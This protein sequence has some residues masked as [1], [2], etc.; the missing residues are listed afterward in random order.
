MSTLTA[1]MGLIKPDLVD[2]R[3][4]APFNLNSDAIDARL[5]VRPTVLTAATTLTMGG[6]YLAN[7]TFAVTL[8]TLTG[9]PANLNFTIIIKNTGTGVIT[10][11]AA[12]TSLIDGAATFGPLAQYGAV[13]LVTDATNWFVI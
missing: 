6:V 12:T 8:P 5:G 13:T 2:P 1:A 7:G 10:P 9:V 4:P 3:S 11:T